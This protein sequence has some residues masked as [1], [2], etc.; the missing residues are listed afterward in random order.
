MAYRRR[1]SLISLGA[2]LSFV[3]LSSQRWSCIPRR[4]DADSNVPLGLMT[5]GLK[6]LMVGTANYLGFVWQHIGDCPQTL[7][8]D[9]TAHRYLSSSSDSMT[10]WFL[11]YFSS[12]WD[13]IFADVSHVHIL[14]Y[15]AFRIAAAFL[16]AMLVLQ[17]FWSCMSQR[18]GQISESTIGM[19]AWKSAIT[20]VVAAL[21]SK[22]LCLYSLSFC[23]RSSWTGLPYYS[24]GHVIC[25]AS[26]VLGG[27][28]A[29]AAMSAGFAHWQKHTRR[30]PNTR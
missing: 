7:R 19:R 4:A 26:S 15:E 2:S 14:A 11:S 27:M 22:Y 6:G 23:A 25:G 9:A 12:G 13:L 17:I 8:A 16:C 21:G 3:C 20:L 10:A 24:K 1:A 29:C 30:L 28:L 18:R 5:G